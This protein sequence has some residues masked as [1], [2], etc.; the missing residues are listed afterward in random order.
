[1]LDQFPIQGNWTVEKYFKLPED[2]RLIEYNDGLLEV[3]PMPD[4]M[5]QRLAYLI[6]AAIEKV[7]VR[8]KRGVCALPPFRL[9][10]NQEKYRYPDIM[11]LS[12]DHLDRFQTDQW[13]YADL[14]VE[15]VSKDD[16]ARDY[17]DK[18][19]EYAQCGIP[20]YWIVDPV[21]NL[22]HV[23]ALDPNQPGVYREHSVQSLRSGVRSV[24]MPEIE[25]DFAT[26]VDQASAIPNRD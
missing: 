6:C 11:Y 15:I 17:V 1:M 21:Q 2:G 19:A 26:L 3:V 18:R 16:P 5:H 12:P 14:V 22:I 13:D 9:Q 10:I 23:L 7:M 25:I 8:A 4:W 24:T 20:E